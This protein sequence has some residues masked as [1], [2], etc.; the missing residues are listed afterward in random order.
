MWSPEAKAMFQAVPFSTVYKSPTLGT[1]QMLTGAMV[2][3][4][5]L[6]HKENVL[7]TAIAGWTRLRTIIW[8]ADR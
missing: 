4:R 8:N 3:L 7:F 1:F 6:D 5:T 2:M